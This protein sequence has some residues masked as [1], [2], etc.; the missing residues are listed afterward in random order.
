MFGRT[1][2]NNPMFGKERIHT[3]ASIALISE[4]KKVQYIMNLVS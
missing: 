4:T 3:P 1:G 2:E